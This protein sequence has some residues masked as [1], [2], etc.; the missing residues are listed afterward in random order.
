MHHGN[1]KCGHHIC[2]KILVGLAW[3]AAI[4]FWL[5]SWKGM[6]WNLDNMGWFYHVIV[7]V[8][9]A[10]STKFCGCCWKQMGMMGK[11]MGCVCNCGECM[12]GKCGGTHGEGHRHM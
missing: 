6:F 11:G 1:C 8:V 5:A 3:L 4:G 10:F 7:F 9:L 2:A 12:G